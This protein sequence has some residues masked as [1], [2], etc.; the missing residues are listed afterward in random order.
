MNVKDDAFITKIATTAA[1][2]VHHE[3]LAVTD[4]SQPEG[5]SPCSS[6]LQAETLAWMFL[7]NA[8]PLDF[9]MPDGVA[10]RVPA[11]KQLVLDMHLFDPSDTP[12]S[13]TLTVSLTGIAESEVKSIAQLVEAGTLQISLPPN[14][15][16]TITGKCTLAKDV[17]LFGVLPHMHALG[18][19]FKASVGSGSTPAMLYNDAFLGE[20]QKFQR[21]DPVAMPAGTPLNVECDYVNTTGA[22]VLYG[23]SAKDEMCFAISYYYPAIDSQGPLCIN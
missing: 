16:T 4:Q 11:G 3:I 17:S 15:A 23:S 6:V 13:T 22:T 5:L 10:Y 19:S 1:L 14:Q 7:G 20:A 9:T 18:T 2:G 21:F 12:I 8:S